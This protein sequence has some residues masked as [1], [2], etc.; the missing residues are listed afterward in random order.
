MSSVVHKLFIDP[1]RDTEYTSQKQIARGNTGISIRDQMRTNHLVL[2]VGIII[3]P[4]P[5]PNHVDGD[6]NSEEYSLNDKVT[7]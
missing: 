3:S 4:V 1:G 7:G 2:T 5:Y 6:T